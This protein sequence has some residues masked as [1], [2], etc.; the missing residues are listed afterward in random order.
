MSSMKNLEDVYVIRDQFINDKS[1][2]D[3]PGKLIAESE[4]VSMVTIPIYQT[5]SSASPLLTSVINLSPP[6][7]TSSTNQ[8]PIF[9]ATTKTTI[10]TLPSPPQQQ[11][12]PES[13]LAIR[14]VA[15]EKKVSELEQANKNLDNINEAVRENVKETALQAPLRER[16]RDL[17][18][19][20]MKEM[21]HQRMFETGLYKSHP[22]HIALYEALEASM[23]RA[24]RDEH[25]AEWEDKK[26]RHDSGVSG[27]SHPPTPQP[28][29]WKK[30]DTRDAPPS[31]SKQQSNVLAEQPVEDIP[32]PDSANISDSEDTD[33]AYL[34]KTKKWP[35][36]FKP[37]PNDDRPATP[38]PAWVIPASHIPDAQNNWANALAST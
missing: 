12:T 23:E 6:K 38:E 37:I 33:S 2:N 27:S 20:D 17:P 29:T 32:I 7:Q 15:L 34:P 10:T 8:T 22:E 24:Q 5:S 26:R 4:V 11:S 30:F 19:A 1:T 28:F 18:E 31:S 36:W 14:V 13:E 35:E 3:E 9:I 16:F 21:L 25:I